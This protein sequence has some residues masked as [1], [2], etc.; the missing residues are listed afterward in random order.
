MS[1][2]DQWLDSMYS[3]WKLVP[4]EGTNS[5]VFPGVLCCISQGSKTTETSLKSA[6]FLGHP[7]IWNRQIWDI[8]FRVDFL[9]SS[10]WTMRLLRLVLKGRRIALCFFLH[11]YIFTPWKISGGTPTNPPYKKRNMIWTKPPGNYVPAVN[12]QG[13]STCFFFF[14]GELFLDFL[15]FCGHEVRDPPFFS[16]WNNL[17][18]WIP[19]CCKISWESCSEN[20]S[21]TSA[22]T[23]AK[24]TW[25]WKVDLLKMYSLHI[26]FPWPC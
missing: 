4:F 5:S 15:V 18:F 16:G 26:I 20:M 25:Q 23:S 1:P 9:D 11:C 3:Y 19:F 13:C 24:L 22:E 2:E 6:I 10:E 21:W 17:A 8:F 7:Q 14:W 12:L